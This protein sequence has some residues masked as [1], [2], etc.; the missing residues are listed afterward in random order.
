LFRRLDLVRCMPHRLR[1]RHDQPPRHLRAA[2]CRSVAS[3][4]SSDRVRERRRR[5]KG[6][7]RDRANSLPVRTGLP[8]AQANAVD[9]IRRA[10]ERLERVRRSVEAREWV[11]RPRRLRDVLWVA[12]R[13]RDSVT[14]HAA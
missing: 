5:D 14:F 2:E 9:H 13:V 3:R 11:Q 12:L 10:L 4:S 1:L 6:K 7:A 8:C